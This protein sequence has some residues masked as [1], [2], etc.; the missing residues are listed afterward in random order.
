MKRDP[1][2]H[3]YGFQ[4]V[5]RTGQ[6][7]TCAYFDAASTL[8]TKFRRSLHNMTAVHARLPPAPLLLERFAKALTRANSIV[9]THKAPYVRTATAGAARRFKDGR[10]VMAYG[11]PT[12]PPGTPIRLWFRGARAVA[13]TVAKS[14]RLQHGDGL[15]A[16]ALDVADIDEGS[17]WQGAEEPSGSSKPAAVEEGV[18]VGAPAETSAGPGWSSSPIVMG[19][20]RSLGTATLA[21]LMPKQRHSLSLPIEFP[22]RSFESMHPI[23][24]A[25]STYTTV[26]VPGATR[27]LVWFD[28]Q[29][30][31]SYNTDYVK[32]YRSSS[33]RRIWGKLL[34]TAG[35]CEL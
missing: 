28:P 25:A 32:L 12:A 8:V 4:F 11:D 9:I 2:P 13:L 14:T 18:V 3:N 26:S 7:A 6:A 35:H 23:S 19:R 24:E 22:L 15:T 10:G 27:L 21:S 34:C 17:V 20:S 5:L 33:K 1:K 30:R 16:A 29:S 31:T